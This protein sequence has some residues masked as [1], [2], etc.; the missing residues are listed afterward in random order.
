MDAE[1]TSNIRT[2]F[3]ILQRK[4]LAYLRLAEALVG[5]E[6]DGYVGAMDLAMTILKVGAK[7]NYRILKNP[8]Y[9]ERVMLDAAGD[10]LY[11]Y[12]IENKD[13]IDIQP[14]MEKYLAS[15]TDSLRY[16]FAAEEFTN[17]IGLHSRGSGDSERN[18]YYALTDTCIA[19]YLGLTEVENKVET[20]LRPITYEDSLNY[21]ADLVIDELALELAWE[22]TRF[23]DLIR[24]A[25]AMGDNDVLAKRVAGRAYENDV[26]YRSNEYQMD[27]DLYGK[28]SNEANWYLP[29]PGAVVEP[30]DPEDVPT[31][32]LPKE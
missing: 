8:V 24:F 2:T 25:K 26:T 3:L 21:I 11:N 19:R 1:F 23:G 13:T 18:E 30:V 12:I 27:A 31:G 9:A 15:C 6:R 5:L 20:I 16:N 17:N 32:E 28:L 4:E 22:G 29:L 7:S 14:R 10:T